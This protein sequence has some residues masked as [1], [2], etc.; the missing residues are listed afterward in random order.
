MLRSQ[1]YP[2]TK[3]ALTFVAKHLNV[4]AMTLRRWFH[5]IQN[6]PPNQEVNE[7]VFDM[8][9]AIQSEMEAILKDMPVAR[10]DAT[11]PQ[12]GTVYGILFDKARLLDGLPTSVVAMLPELVSELE[13]GGVKPSDVFN[14]MLAKA[15]AANANR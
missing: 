6:P 3:G 15:K 1:G 9:A 10:A 5:G 12:L 13:R 14:A 7:K 4:P 11:Y 8:R 2:E